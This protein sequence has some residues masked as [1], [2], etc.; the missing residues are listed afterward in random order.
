MNLIVA[1]AIGLSVVVI[2]MILLILAGG[3]LFGG[4]RPCL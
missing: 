1:A 3:G 4:C 2:V